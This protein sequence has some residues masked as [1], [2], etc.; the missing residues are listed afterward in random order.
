MSPEELPV[1]VGRISKGRSLQPDAWPGRFEA[2]SGSAGPS[3]NSCILFF[4]GVWFATHRAAAEYAAE[5][6]AEHFRQRTGNSV[7]SVLP[8]R[9]AIHTLRSPEISQEFFRQSFLIQRM[10]RWNRHRH[11]IVGIPEKN[12]Q[13]LSARCFQ[14]SKQCRHRLARVR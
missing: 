11:R 10:I 1:I 5:Q 8:N 7:A 3:R 14:I 4:P 12:I 6:S 2:D 9:G 13:C